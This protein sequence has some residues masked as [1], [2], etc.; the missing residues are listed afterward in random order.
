MA[1]TLLYIGQDQ[2]YWKELQQEIKDTYPTAESYEYLTLW[3][4]AGATVE[5][6]KEIFAKKPAMVFL[7]LSNEIETILKLATLIR[8][9]NRTKNISVVGLYP[10]G[11]DP[12]IRIKARGAGIL[13]SHLKFKGETISVIYDAFYLENIETS[14]EPKLYQVNI[15][16]GVP[17]TMREVARVN[18]YNEDQIHLES[19]I[20]YDPETYIELESDIHKEI[21]LSNQFIIDGITN[22]HL[23]YDHLY[24]YNLLYNYMD[25]ITAPETD[26]PYELE[27]FE[28]LQKKREEGMDQVF[29]E[30]NKWLEL[31]RK[32]KSK[33]KNVRILIVE[34]EFKSLDQS[35]KWIGDYP[36]S[37]R[38]QSNYVDIEN[39][40]L[41]F[42]P[43]FIVYQ[44]EKAP[45]PP[46]DR[47]E[48]ELYD[49]KDYNDLSGLG[50]IVSAVKQIEDYSPVIVV[51]GLPGKNSQEI[52]EKLEYPKVL[53]DKEDFNFNKFLNLGEVYEKQHM[54]ELNKSLEGKV[55]ISKND[56]MSFAFIK[57]DGSL[58][59]I[60]EFSVVIESGIDLPP[61]STFMV[62][63]PH[64][65]LFTIVDNRSSQSLP[66]NTYYGLIHSYGMEEIKSLRQYI[67]SAMKKKN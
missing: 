63:K 17:I 38:L 3:K 24:A 15:P 66:K 8:R 35:S 29:E 10:P 14:S 59:K 28:R 20:K 23:N 5:Y 36:Y 11:I 58:K 52:A 7:D 51:F 26:D 47:A 61:G 64:S 4:G 67:M 60:S 21:T 48:K 34:K 32:E 13:I 27:N 16:D 50:T 56:L 30:L 39:D 9:E 45:P 44:Y 57:I 25:E 49:K 31:R 1:K 46:E 43:N 37:I 2:K 62:E 18:F 54:D 19:D 6:F 33:A 65:F 53:I 22:M 40:I 42:T 55:F 41:H 12:S